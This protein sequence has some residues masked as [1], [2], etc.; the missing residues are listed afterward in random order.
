MRP[1][2]SG[3]TAVV[4][5]ATGG[6]GLVMTRELAR[7][8]ARVVLAVRNVEKGR[9]L[10]KDIAGETEVLRLDL[11]SLA[12]VRRFAAEY[13]ATHDRLHLLLNNAGIHTARRQ[14]T[15]DGHELT[16]QTN[17]LGHFLLTL[18]LLDVLRASAPARVVNVASEAHWLGR[19]D[20]DDL[21]GERRWSG[22]KAYCQSKLAN[23]EFSYALARRLAGTGVTANAA[24]PGSVRTGWARGEDSGLLRLAVKTAT[25][26]L[27]RPETGAARVLRVATDPAL[28]GVT[29]RYFV[30][31]K[32]ARSAPWSR[33]EEDWAR[34]WRESERLTGLAP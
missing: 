24:H 16:F 19:L 11:A 32:E 33:R 1:D 34:L 28:D 27:V 17:H 15:A 8:G 29:G 18:E 9:A 12:D 7:M 5:G 22:V 3:R 2:L 30:R 10:A 25:P 13:R 23:V 4:T 26:I 31:G 14:V 21:M 6:I 20:F